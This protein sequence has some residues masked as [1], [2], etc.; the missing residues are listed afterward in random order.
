MLDKVL[1]RIESDKFMSVPSTA[2]L[3]GV[4]KTTLYRRIKKERM[5]AFDLGGTLFVPKSEVRRLIKKTCLNCSRLLPDG[6]LPPICGYYETADM[7]SPCKDWHN[8]F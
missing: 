1:I 5:V 4:H 3:L 8:E 7:V 6:E 2:K